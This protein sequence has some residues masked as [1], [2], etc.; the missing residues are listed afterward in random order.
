MLCC[1][2]LHSDDSLPA[3]LNWI[4]IIKKKESRRGK[5]NAY[6]LIAGQCHVSQIKKKQG[7][8]L[9]NQYLV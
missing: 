8:Q 2:S 5:G 9:P 6:A 3:N 1:F 7:N 4:F